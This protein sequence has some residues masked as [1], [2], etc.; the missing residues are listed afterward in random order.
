MKNKIIL[1]VSMLLPL[2]SGC[3]SQ[4]SEEPTA[5][6]TVEPTV[7]TTEEP[8]VEST[9]EPTIEPTAESTVE[10]TLEPTNYLETKYNLSFDT[11][12]SD[13]VLNYLLNGIG[14]NY[15]YFPVLPYTVMDVY[16][17]CIEDDENWMEAFLIDTKQIVGYINDSTYKKIDYVDFL[18]IDY[19]S[20]GIVRVCPQYQ[21]G[22]MDKIITYEDDPLCVS[23]YNEGKLPEKCDGKTIALHFII[24]TYEFENGDKLYV[25]DFYKPSYSNGFYTFHKVQRYLDEKMIYPV[26]MLNDPIYIMSFDTFSVS[27]S[28]IEK[29]FYIH[30]SDDKEISFYNIIKNCIDEEEAQTD[31]YCIKINYDKFLSFCGIKTLIE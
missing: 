14:G 25:F 11:E 28:E 23:Y 16:D 5:E 7:E 29:E 15:D 1:L 13:L 4:V 22:I 26:K 19:R 31:C 9:E 30:F 10:P 2:I 3:G 8:T 6:P 18:G 17:D 20:S 24:N 12:L 21:K 27:K